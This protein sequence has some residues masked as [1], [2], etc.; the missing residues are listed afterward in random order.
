MMLAASRLCS[1]APHRTITP[2]PRQP[3]PRPQSPTPPTPRGQ[4]PLPPRRPRPLPLP[5]APAPTGG[6]G[7]GSAAARTPP[8]PPA[9]A[10]GARS[11]RTC[12]AP[13][14]EHANPHR[15]ISV[16]TQHLALLASPVPFIRPKISSG[17]PSS[18][19]LLLKRPH[20]L[21]RGPL[22]LG[23]VHEIV[24]DKVDVRAEA[25]AP[26]H[27]RQLLRVLRGVVHAAQEGVLEG[28]AAAS[29]LKVG[30]AVLCRERENRRGGGCGRV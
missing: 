26:E 11:P 7:S 22:V 15:A 3:A 21:L 4:H 18:D 13:T 17:A 30:A 19:E 1:A 27:R 24:G 5:S 28:D 10:S 25:E 16:P 29:G 2:A 9:R 8:P 12:G 20:S 6:S 14:A 23:I